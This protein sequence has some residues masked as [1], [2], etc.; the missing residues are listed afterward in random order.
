[1]LEQNMGRLGYFDFDVWKSTK[2]VIA[3]PQGRQMRGRVCAVDH[4]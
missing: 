2:V 1:M 3:G 4:S